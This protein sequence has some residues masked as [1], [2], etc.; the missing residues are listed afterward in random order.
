MRDNL[1]SPPHAT[2]TELE[3]ELL[4]A[5]GMACS[6]MSP[7]QLRKLQ[8][9]WAHQCEL[10]NAGKINRAAVFARVAAAQ[11]GSAWPR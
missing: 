9:L 8:R 5:L 1:P 3:V 11:G 2:H 7:R 6:L 10:I 4:D